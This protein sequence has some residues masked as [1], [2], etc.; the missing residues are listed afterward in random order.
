MIIYTC[1]YCK[2]QADD[3]K[4]STTRYKDKS[5]VCSKCAEQLDKIRENN[6]EPEYLNEREIYDQKVDESKEG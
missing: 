6:G 1:R 4:F 3:S 5:G 2:L